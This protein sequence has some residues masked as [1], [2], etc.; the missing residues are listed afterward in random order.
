MFNKLVLMT[1]VV[2]I[3]AAG[4]A[5]AMSSTSYDLPWTT[6]GGGSSGGGDR[7]SSSYQL[8]DVTGQT[9]PGTAS[10]T[11]YRLTGG[12]LSIMPIDTGTM[13]KV[14]VALQGDNRPSPEGWEVPLTVCFCPENSDNDTLLNPGTDVP[15]F[16]GTANAEWING[17]TRST[18]TLGPVNPGT[19]DI[20]ADSSTTL[21][22]VKRS[23]HIP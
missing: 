13:V 16:T 6:G 3:V 22:N 4:V 7:S 11:N 2:I 21:L 23:V 9:A 19:Y 20:T 14:Y 8:T 17:G 18:V 10:S 1:V 5:V 15:C 12:F